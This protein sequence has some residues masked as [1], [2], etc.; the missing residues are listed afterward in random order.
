MFWNPHVVSF[1][2]YTE[3]FD[4]DTTWQ[5]KLSLEKTYPTLKDFINQ[6]VTKILFKSNYLSSPWSKSKYLWSCQVEN[7]LNFSKLT[8]LLSVG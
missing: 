4:F 2:I 6:K 3:T 8:Q 5:G 1:P 7:F